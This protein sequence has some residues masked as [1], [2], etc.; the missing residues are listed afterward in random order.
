[1]QAKGCG[2]GGKFCRRGIICREPGAITAV[3]AV[4][5]STFFLWHTACSTERGISGP[6]DCG[7]SRSFVMIL[8]AASTALNLLEALTTKKSSAA[9]STGL[10]ALLLLHQGQV[11]VGHGTTAINVQRPPIELLGGGQIPC[12][13]LR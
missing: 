8:A 11:E 4:V 9:P 10:A 13:L 6:Q 1:M 3:K 5:L 12:F 2:E 7:I